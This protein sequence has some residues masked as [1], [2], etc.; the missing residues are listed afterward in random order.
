MRARSDPGTRMLEALGTWAGVSVRTEGE[1]LTLRF[2]AAALAAAAERL[3]V[4]GMLGLLSAMFLWSVYAFPYFGPVANVEEVALTYTSAE[5][6][7]RYG[8][9]PSGFLPDYSTSSRPADH[10]YVYNHM[11]PGPE[12]SV[13]LLLKASGGS[14]RIVRVAYWLVFLAG[15]GSY[16][17]FARL[18]LARF[19]LKGA[20]FTL[21]FLNPY[22]LLRSLDHPQFAT[23]PFWAFTPLV[24]LQAYYR[25]G[26]RW[27][28]AVAAAMGLLS[29]VY[30]DYLSLS[31][32]VFSWVC[33]YL[34]QLLRLDGRHLVAFLAVVAAGIGLHL[35]QNFLYLGPQVFFEE[36][37]MTLTN[38]LVGIPSKDE[39]KVFYREYGVVHHGSTPIQPL[40]LLRQILAGLWVPGLGYLLVT[41]LVAVGWPLAAQARY[42][43]GGVITTPRGNVTQALSGFVALAL[44]IAGAVTLPMLMFPALTQ[45]YALAGLGLNRYFGAVGAIAVLLFAIQQLVTRR[46]NGTWSIATLAWVFL[47]VLVG[48]GFYEGISGSARRVVSA[49]RDFRTFESRSLEE[50]RH[51][52]AGHVYMTNINPVLVG[53]FAGEA[54][55]GVCE[56]SSVPEG[57]GVDPERCRVANARQQAELSQARPRYF[58]FFRGLFPGFSECLPSEGLPLLGRGGDSCLELMQDRL[59]ARYERVYR[60]RLFDV[61]DLSRAVG[62]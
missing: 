25:T 26:S 11:P 5:N 34:T 10:P 38:R 47:A 15:I 49:A 23:F 52:F 57:G 17:A 46:P 48:V 35:L 4:A 13:A 8:F 6:F 21:L 31:V 12:I 56:P 32:V 45:E 14:Y 3:V 41:V 58:F 61:F 42:R 50:I 39:L 55:H 29:S 37:R 22:L 33:L 59:S 27:W 51:R 30:L 54:G 43:G 9:M 36:L 16:L 24:A 20:G 40:G 53:F 1:V 60:S 2:E 18:V 28:L 19:G 44:W 7:I 62:P